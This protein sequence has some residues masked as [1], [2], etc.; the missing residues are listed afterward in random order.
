MKTKTMRWF[1]LGLLFLAPQSA[2]AEWVD[3]SKDLA[4]TDIRAVAADPADPQRLYAA[5]ERRMFRSEDRG[6]HWKQA[7]SVRGTDNTIHFV[8]VDPRDSRRIFV[9]SERG[10]QVSQDQGKSWQYLYRGM[11]DK[12]KAVYSL[13]AD[14][15]NPAILWVGT[16]DGL[17]RLT[18]KEPRAVPGIPAVKVFS[19]FLTKDGPAEKLWVAAAKGIYKSE[20]SGEHWERVF[21]EIGKAG[22]PAGETSLS[23]FQ[24]EEL[25]PSPAMSNVIRFP[26]TDALLAA[27]SKGV[28]QGSGQ[29]WTAL[30]N[31]ALPDQ[32]I[33]YLAG[34][35]EAFYA[36]TDRGVF[37]WDKRTEAFK[38]VSDGLTS[39]EVRM[40]AYDGPSGDLFAATRKGV[41]RYPKPDFKPLE[42]PA[43][44]KAPDAREILKQFEN[45]P[46]IQKIQNAA[47]RYA[48]VH[49]DKIE[50]WRRAAARKALFPTLS[51]TA[52]SGTDHNVDID[53]GGTNDPDKFIMGP[54][55]TNTDWHAGISW[56]LGDLIWNN[57][58]TSIDTRSKLMVE[59][60]D[61]VLNEVTHLYYERR[62]LQVEMRLTP[63]K[64]LP[65][66]IERQLK[67]DELT[68]GID[69]LT[70][71]YLSKSLAEI[72]HA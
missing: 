64:E 60:R 72:P 17:V 7:L 8:L 31:S 22:E 20:D 2:Q 5:S 28:W 52:D 66:E 44:A 24:I 16:A 9:A 67:L 13:S 15:E 71:G 46:S 12:A 29:D 56:D 68:A 4:E 19:I 41:F 21:V 45:E 23:Q 50:N 39:K 18:G 47:I 69:A 54:E 25:A 36:A 63:A 57:D 33:N 59:L 49:P 30:K 6:G 70:G 55:E 35:A 53:R 11:G 10:I 51:L 26:G 40:L 3:L 58:Q 42:A 43:E 34:S 1:F 62:R 14:L 32:K 61:D 65:L 27:S 38:D 48:E 37:R